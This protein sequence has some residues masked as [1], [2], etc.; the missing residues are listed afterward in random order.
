M[1]LK[2]DVLGTE[3]TL[4]ES[5]EVSDP[6]LVGRDGY[7]DTS[8][9]TCVVDEMNATTPDCKQNLHEYKKSVIRHELIHAF[10]HECGLDSCS[11]ADNEMMVDWLAIQFPKLLKVFTDADCL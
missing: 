7:C 3:Y 6:R 10:F 5:N 1:T 11:W 4:K 2:I 9:K 8:V